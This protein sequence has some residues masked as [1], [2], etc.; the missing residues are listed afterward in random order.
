MKRSVF[1]RIAIYTALMVM[2]LIIL[3]NSSLTIFLPKKEKIIPYVAGKTAGKPV[4]LRHLGSGL[5]EP[6]AVAVDKR[7]YIYIADSGNNKVKVYQP[8]G[9][10]IKIYGAMDGNDI[11]FTYPNAIAVDSQEI[12]YVGE[13]KTGR[14]QVFD[15]S[16]N[17]VRVI[18]GGST[19]LPLAPLALAVDGEDRIHVAN[20]TGEV[21]VLD[22]EGKL[23]LRFGE[24]GVQRG[25]LSY[26]NGIAIDAAGRIVVSDSGNAR[27]Q[28]FNNEGKYLKSALAAQFGVALPRGIAVGQGNRIY[29]ADVFGH[30]V[31]ELNEDLEL[32]H[33]LGRLGQQEGELKF[34]NGV[35]VDAMG[36]VYVAERGNNRMSVF[37][38]E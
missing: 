4:F 27:I 14:I 2:G 12:I 25:K 17:L 10:L 6:L 34:P 16:A 5:S 29:V 3:A 36:N 8:N 18:D 7:G 31:V 21:F 13:L 28:I 9:N 22:K 38:W 1:L 32:R 23:L 20:R 35:A 19:G 33:I 37:G 15:Y 24:P 30:Q 26:P 11:A